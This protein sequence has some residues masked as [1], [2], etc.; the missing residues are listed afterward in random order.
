[1]I[2]W[3]DTAGFLLALEVATAITPQEDAEP[4]AACLQLQFMPNSSA[5]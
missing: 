5:I 2:S 1:M 3:Y 4:A